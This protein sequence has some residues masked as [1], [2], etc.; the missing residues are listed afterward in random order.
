MATLT[1]R[2][3]AKEAASCLV[4]RNPLVPLSLQGLEEVLRPGAGHPV[5]ALRPF[6]V[7]GAAGEGYDPPD[8]Q[9]GGEPHGVTEPFVMFSGHALVG[10]ERVA[11]AGEGADLQPL[12]ST[13]CR[14]LSL[15]SGSPSS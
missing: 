11:A 2:S 13:A 15:A 1:P 12:L 14:N 4:G 9:L 10:V 6:G 3:R 7:A 8:P 5:G